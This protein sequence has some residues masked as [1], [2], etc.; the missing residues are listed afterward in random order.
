[1]SIRI[2]GKVNQR[3]QT[4]RRVVEFQPAEFY[5]HGEKDNSRLELL[6]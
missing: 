3:H 1:M 6:I 4:C 5:A 2:L